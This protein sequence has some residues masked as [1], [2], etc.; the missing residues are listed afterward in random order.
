MFVKYAENNYVMYGL[1]RGSEKSCPAS[2]TSE[3]T[4][5]RAQALYAPQ[6]TI[7]RGEAPAWVGVAL[8]Q[9]LADVS[10]RLNR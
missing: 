2:V 7:L 5:Q 9:A 1:P 10:V 3:C 8:E 4:T 6:R